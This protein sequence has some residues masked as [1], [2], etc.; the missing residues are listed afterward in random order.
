MLRLRLAY[1]ALASGVIM[2]LSGCYSTCDSGPVFSRFFSSRCCGAS[3]ETCGCSSQ[4]S[5]QMPQMFD[6][7]P[8]QGPFMGP[9]PMPM[10]G[11]IPIG[12]QGPTLPPIVTKVPQAPPVAYNPLP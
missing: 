10:P 6:V 2:T 4:H 11:P 3:S 1:L 8:G 7:P 9:P 5:S 12:A